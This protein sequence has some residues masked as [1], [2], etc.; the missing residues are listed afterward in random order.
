MVS[1]DRRDDELLEWGEKVN[2]TEFQ[3]SVALILFN[4]SLHEA[5]LQLNSIA[6]MLC[7]R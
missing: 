2:E 1:G 3:E 7:Y 6:F 5:S 4:I